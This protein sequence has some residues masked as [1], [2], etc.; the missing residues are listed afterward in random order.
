[1]AVRN[2][3]EMC[4]GRAVGVGWSDDGFGDGG[5]DVWK[6]DLLEAVAVDVAEG[7]CASQCDHRGGVDEGVVDAGEEV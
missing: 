2:A 7:A 3:V 5:E 4:S 1:M 6:V